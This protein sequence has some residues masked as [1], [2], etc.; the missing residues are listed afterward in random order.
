MAGTR[1]SDSFAE[2]LH[3]LLQ[4]VTDLK[5]TDD[6][7]LPFAI[8]VETM[9]LQRLKAGANAAMQGQPPSGGPTGL[10]AGAAMTPGPGMVPPGGPGP[11]PGGPGPMPGGPGPMM[12]GMGG[13]G[14]PPP[15]AGLGPAP[16]P[17]LMA[18]PNFPNPDELRRALTTGTT[19][20]RLNS[21]S[22][23]LAG[24]V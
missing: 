18:G 3:K 1:T 7:D 20:S 11:M 22:S 21:V 9:I 15:G 13:P 24:L 5:T 4:Q 17:G 8:N 2:G 16:V 6:A 23:K 14:G 12:A 10:G 19:A